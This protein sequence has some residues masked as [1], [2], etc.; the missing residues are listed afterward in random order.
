MKAIKRLTFAFL[1]VLLLQAVFWSYQNPGAA[2][3]KINVADAQRAWMIGLDAAFALML[4]LL[5]VIYIKDRKTKKIIAEQAATLITERQQLEAAMLE[6]EQMSSRIES[7]IGNLPGMVYQC[8]YN[9]PIYPL[10]FVS[11]GSRELIG[12]AP[13][14]LIGAD[15]MV[16]GINKYMQMV[17]PDDL[18]SIAKKSE[19]TLELGLN[20]EHTYRLIMKDGS[21]KWVWERNRVL[22]WNPDGSPYLLDGY[23]FDIT[24]Q[25]QLEAAK[26]ANHAKS[27]FLAK[28]S[29]E[30][31]T[32]M[33]AILGITEIL[34]Q[35]ETL[36]P[37]IKEAHGKIYNSG[38]LLLGIIN[39]I[40]DLSKIEA[41]KLEL[42]QGEYSVASLINDTT[43]LNVTRIGDKP[44]EFELSVDENTPA[45]LFGDELR[46]RQILNN[47][48]SNAF[49]YTERGVVKLLI[50][51][52]AGDKQPEETTLVIKVND[53]GC[54]MTKEQ[55]SVVFDA[56]TRFNA[57]SNRMTEGTGLGMNIT[58]NLA[59][60]MNGEITVKSEPGIGTTFIVRLPQRTA[61][62][63]VLGRELA[64]S[65][66][67]FRINSAKH[68]RRA[69]VVLEPMPYGSVLVV[70]DVELNLYV[71]RGLLAP[72]K[73]SVDTVMSGFDAIDKIKSGSAYDIVFMDHMMPK[74]DGMEAVKI[75]RGLGYT[76]PI[77][78]LTA[79]ALAGQADMYLANGFDG[80]IS[81]P[82]DVRELNTALK[83][84]I[85]AK[86]PR[87]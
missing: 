54:G 29:H 30:I 72:Y 71:A 11:E 39:D 87:P 82:I 50:S 79:N 35:D 5:T 56:Y 51:A 85:R 68:I 70:D 81:K 38:E 23:V 25:Q 66:Q 2:S 8:V 55:L 21:V 37:S 64:K 69:Q 4:V 73:L 49:K 45:A 27:E 24:E 48:L 10:T 40:L 63:G 18:E 78:A 22:E 19:E 36:A 67:E 75:I 76:R 12:Y 52:C 31:R 77:V 28:M 84:F 59:R 16:G 53:T 1:S 26:A 9:H 17:H 14:E 42:T 44:I 15:N 33:N 61:G 80:F 46:I 65:L 32:P 86:Q 7:I 47:L 43:T 41:G 13:E 58:Y 60:L 6:Q 20:Y 74:M 34:L 3:E 83:K 62:G 57:E